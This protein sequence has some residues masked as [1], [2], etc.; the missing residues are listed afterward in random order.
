VG[1]ISLSGDPLDDKTWRMRTF[2][3]L[4]YRVADDPK[5]ALQLLDRMARE[6]NQP[7]MRGRLFIIYRWQ[8]LWL[9]AI[10]DLNQAE[11]YHRRQKD[12]QAQSRSWP[13]VEPYR[14]AW[15]AVIEETAAYILEYRGQHRAA[16]AGF[17]R[18]RQAAPRA[19]DTCQHLIADLEGPPFISR[20]VAQRRLDRRYS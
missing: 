17:P 4:Q 16:E 14:S 10:G 11:A 15:A 20:T 8:A 13:N 2:L 18:P 3:V 12:L 5:R 1:S 9:L 19:P 7:H 6:Y